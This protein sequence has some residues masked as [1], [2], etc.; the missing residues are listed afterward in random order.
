[1]KGVRKGHIPQG[2]SSKT[3]CAAHIHG[4]VQYVEWEALNTMIHQNTEVVSQECASDTQCPCRRHNKDLAN[5]E[6]GHRDAGC[7]GFR[8]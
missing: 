4:V 5:D 8:Q 7:I 3:H 2:G 1:M 6:E